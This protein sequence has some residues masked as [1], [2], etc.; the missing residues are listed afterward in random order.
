M[1]L[2]FASIPKVILKSPKVSM[3][4]KTTYAQ[5]M[6]YAWNGSGFPGRDRLAEENGCH[7]NTVDK[8][9]K[10]LKELGLITV[11]RRGHQRTN[12][13]IIEDITEDIIAKL[14]PAG[15]NITPLDDKGE[16]DDKK[17]D[18][19]KK[20]DDIPYERIVKY[21]NE[22][23]GTAFKHNTKETRRYIKARFA[24]GFTTKDFK[25]VIDFKVSEWKTDPDMMQYLRPLTLFST[26]FEGYL[27]AA[28]KAGN[29]P[30]DGGGGKTSIPNVSNSDFLKEYG[31]K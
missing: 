25:K 5:L 11:K 6:D 4:G 23:A 22:Q 17:D 3:Q 20:K 29:R 19:P 27:N 7:P 26:K 2:G 28:M 15:M 12:L 21:L 16:D 24:D 18:Q 14:E 31:L 13:Y 1:A 9:I 8:A 10:E 30:P